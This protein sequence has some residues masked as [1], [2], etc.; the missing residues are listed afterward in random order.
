MTCIN[1]RSV[2]S[3]GNL[4]ASYLFTGGPNG[5]TQTEYLMI[6]DCAR[7]V[8]VLQDKL[9]VNFGGGLF[10][11]TKMNAALSKWL[12]EAKQTKPDPRLKQ[13]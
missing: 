2:H 6:A 7:S 9:G 1:E 12:C 5:V 13:F 10:D 11:S 4:R 8:T 3:N